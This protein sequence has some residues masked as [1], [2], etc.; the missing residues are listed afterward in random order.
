MEAERYARESSSSRLG[1]AHAT[2]AYF[3]SSDS[4]RLV[5]QSEQP[6]FVQQRAH[7]VRD[8]ARV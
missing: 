1:K 3:S 2:R 5:D 7:W 4:K 6:D 8:A